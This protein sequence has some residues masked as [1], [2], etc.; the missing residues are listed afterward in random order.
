M[1]TKPK[2][3]TKGRKVYETLKTEEE[4]SI[5]LMYRHLTR[6]EKSAVYL[7]LQTL[8]WGELNADTTDR[9]PWKK[10]SRVIG[11]PES[12]RAGEKTRS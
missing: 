7:I 9:M 4:Q 11:L 8:A 3:K 2:S 1:Q 5:V 10:F 6:W 12:A